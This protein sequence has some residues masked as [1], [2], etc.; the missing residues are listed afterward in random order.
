MAGLMSRNTTL[1]LPLSFA[2]EVAPASVEMSDNGVDHIISVFNRQLSDGLHPGAQ[3]VVLRHG[4]VVV[5]RASGLANKNRILPV[6]P[7]TPFMTY[8][9]SKT[10]T[11]ICIHRLIEEGRVE[12]D[13]PIARYWPA[14]GCNGKEKATIR[15]AFLHQAGIS[16]RGF[17]GEF[18]RVWNWD[19]IL[20]YVAGLKAEFEPG[21]RCAYHLVN[22]GFI[23]G[24][25]VQHVTGMR[26]DVYLQQTYLDPMGMKNSY[27]SLP[28]SEQHRAAW[29]YCGNPRDRLFVYPV[30]IPFIR[31][32]LIP[33]GSFNSTARE[34]ATFYQMLLNGGKYAGRQ[35]LRP[36]TITAATALGYEGID[37]LIKATVRWAHGFHLGGNPNQDPN[38]PNGMG[39]KST[40]RTFGH[41]G[42]DSSMAW[43]DPDADIAVAFTCNR[44]I[45]ERA[46]ESRWQAISDAVWDA[47]N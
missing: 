42:Q 12:W 35:Y 6:T 23:L 34:L 45:H 33:A 17:W 15:H 25:V 41:F 1:D 29:I 24:G 39:R 13:A 14:W 10:F 47:L 22:Y 43:A 4:Q 2:G 19:L 44:L 20:R 7:D 40:I 3:L 9:V 21:T 32:A 5:D 27:L 38:I 36:E 37:G 16:L 11:G 8:S 31:S 18:L 28:R 26:P 30:N 46:A